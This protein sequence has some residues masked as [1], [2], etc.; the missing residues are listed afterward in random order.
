MNVKLTEVELIMNRAG[1]DTRKVEKVKE[2]CPYH[3]FTY[4]VMWKPSKCCQYPLHSVKS[5]QGKLRYANKETAEKITSHFRRSTE[6]NY[7]FP[8][9]QSICDSCRKKCNLTS[10]SKDDS[11]STTETFINRERQSKSSAKAIISEIAQT[12]CDIDLDGESNMSPQDRG[13]NPPVVSKDANDVFLE[14]GLSPLKWQVSS[15]VDK[16]S[17][18]TKRKLKWKGNNLFN[19][20]KDITCEAMAP[21][22]GELLKTLLFNDGDEIKSQAVEL[23]DLTKSLVDAY[24]KAPNSRV[25]LTILSL[26]PESLK[27]KQIMSFL[28]V[29]NTKLKKQDN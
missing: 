26:V 19:K 5:K 25:E 29:A 2:I 21:G 22:Q 17:E 15:S 9:G 13:Y 6:D 8:I 3:R 7:C 27:Q 16:L 14:Y 10:E 1:V 24:E 18:E 23:D 11:F 28:G 20:I 12:S 4:G